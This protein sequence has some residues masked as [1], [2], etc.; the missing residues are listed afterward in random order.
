[1]DFLYFCPREKSIPFISHRSPLASTTNFTDNDPVGPHFEWGYGYRFGFGHYFCNHHW[2]VA[3]N[4]THFHGYT[5]QS[6]GSMGN[7]TDGRFPI[8]ST[9]PSTTANDYVLSGKMHWSLH[10]DLVDME[11]G[12]TWK[13]SIFTLRPYVAL[14]LGLVDQE[15]DLQYKGGV[16]AG[17][18]DYVDM[19]NN[20]VGGGVKVGFNPRMKLSG[21]WNLYA[22][23]SFAGYYGTFHVH[24]EEN[25]NLDRRLNQHRHLNRVAWV[26]DVEGGLMWTSSPKGDKTSFTLR[27]GWEYLVLFH[28]NVL[29]RGVYR[30]GFHNRNLQMQGGVAS[31]EFDF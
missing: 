3:L 21:G 14:A 23:G 18:I 28:Q 31:F 29:Q 27:L 8:W 10:M 16:F 26:S 13:P 9:G 17:G 7:T 1:G 15:F 24:Q 5:R 25:F 20:Y 22:K 19:R 6:R 30:E 4:W 12:R 11:F 2:D